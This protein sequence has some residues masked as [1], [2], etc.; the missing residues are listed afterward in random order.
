LEPLTQGTVLKLK[1]AAA[2]ALAIVCAGALS[3]QAGADPV[4]AAAGDIACSPSN[5]SFNGGLGTSTACRQK[6]TSDL[7]V[8]AGLAAVLALGDNQYEKGSLAEFKGAFDPSWGRVKPIILPAAGNHE[9]GTSQAAG[10]FDYFDGVGN[11]TGPAG[12]RGKGYYSYDIGSWHLIALNTNDNGCGYVA[13]GAGSAQEQWLKADLASHPSA[14]TLAYWHHPRFSSGSVGN[15]TYTQALWQDLYNARAD[16]VLNGHAHSYERFAP[17]TPTGALDRTNGIREFVI[18]TGGEDFQSLGKAKPNSEV[19]QNSTFGVL[20]LT[21]HATSYDWRFSPVAG[22]TFTDSGTA[23]CHPRTSDTQAPSAPTNLTATAP[24]AN[25]VNLSWTASS[26]NTGV[27]GYRIFRGGV[28]IGTSSSTSY[29]DT[30]V[31]PGTSYSYYVV[32]YDGAGNTSSPSNT[33]SVKTP[34]AVSLTFTPSDDAYVES[35]LPSSN[36]GSATEIVSDNSPVKNLMVR[37]SVSGV[38]ASRVIGAKLRLYCVDGSTGS[39]G[40]FYPTTSTAWSE[41]TVTWQT[42]PAAGSTLLGSLGPVSSGKWYEIDLTSLVTG[43][44]TYSVR[45]TSPSYDGAHYASK[46]RTGGVAP[47]LIVTTD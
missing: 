39:G 4:I 25:R 19:R 29:A 47:Q 23:F 5:S 27:A 35:D 28:Q 2:V 33:V 9:Y 3:A 11:L 17:Q 8:N 7:L 45:A 1:A 36:F 41:S 15:A 6:Y 21:L 42:A 43:D 10:Y 13:C 34:T 16:V 44:G 12:A 30:T 40:Q 46:E 26:D 14:C 18:G 22:K 37:F 24:A 38:G 31:A 32:A 20:K